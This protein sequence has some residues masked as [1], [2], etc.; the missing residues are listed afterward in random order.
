MS[1]SA[2]IY[3]RCACCGHRARTSPS[4]I[5]GACYARAAL[6]EAAAA[7]IE[8]EAHGPLRA[9]TTDDTGPPECDEEDDT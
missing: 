1:A 2:R 8:A 3:T 9:L 6:R 5:C 4:G 7:A